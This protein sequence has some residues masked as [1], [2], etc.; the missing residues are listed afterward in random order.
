MR[1]TIESIQINTLFLLFRQTNYYSIIYLILNAKYIVAVVI[2]RFFQS[3]LSR[4]VRMVW[5]LV[6]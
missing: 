1:L 6:I 3:T 5:F 4:S 2:E